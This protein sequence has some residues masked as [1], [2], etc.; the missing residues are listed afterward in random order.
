MLRKEIKN[1]LNLINIKNRN[2]N[3]KKRIL[4]IGKIRNTEVYLFVWDS[5]LSIFRNILA[6]YGIP[7]NK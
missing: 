3:M 2:K 6:N 5:E 4:R 1:N 7:I